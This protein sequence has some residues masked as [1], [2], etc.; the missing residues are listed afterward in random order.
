M[1]QLYCHEHPDTLVLATEVLDSRPGKVVLARSPFYPGGGGQPGDEGVIRWN[2]GEARIV[3]FE[4]GGE[5][6]WHVLDSSAEISGHIEAAV[7]PRFR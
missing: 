6:L 1:A 4:Y 3:G 5:A 2:G 7:D